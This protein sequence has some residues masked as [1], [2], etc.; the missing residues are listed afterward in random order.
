MNKL[1]QYYITGASLVALTF[2]LNVTNVN[3]ACTAMPT[4][5]SLGYTKTS[6]PS[7]VTP[8]KCPFDE[9]KLFC[10]AGGNCSQLGYNVTHSCLD[11]ETTLYC[12]FDKNYKKCIMTCD[13]NLYP[14]FGCDERYGTCAECNGMWRYTSCISGVNYNWATSSCEFVDEI[15]YNVGDIVYYDGYALGMVFRVDSD[16]AYIYSFDVYFDPANSWLIS[17]NPEAPDDPSDLTTCVGTA[18]AGGSN[19]TPQ[20]YQ[21]FNGENNTNQIYAACPG[22]VEPVD[23][24]KDYYPY[25]CGEN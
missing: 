13:P 10:G 25:A 12:P 18:V 14:L 16:Y 1:S 22:K 15:E 5:E 2:S 17:Q 6:C 20:A 21:D 23:A 8:L 11:G 3:A 19:Y 24:V 7:G 9:T 4:C